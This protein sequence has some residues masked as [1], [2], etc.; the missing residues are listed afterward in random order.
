MRT[1]DEI[2]AEW[3]SSIGALLREAFDAGYAKG[4]DDVR[5]QLDVFLYQ[6]AVANGVGLKTPTLLESAS[7]SPLLN[8]EAEGRA[9]PGTVKPGILRL[10][11]NI[12]RGMTTEEIITATEFKPNSVRGTLS[13][14]QTENHIERIGDRWIAVGTFKNDSGETITRHK[15]SYT[16]L[17]PAALAENENPGATN[18]G[19]D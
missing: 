5:K 14:L 15:G 19:A 11:R 12:E 4:R 18:A 7:S 6:A 16:V 10:L 8:T 9:A 17:S 3:E 1:I 13:T 2:T